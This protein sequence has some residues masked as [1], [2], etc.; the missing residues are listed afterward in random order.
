MR[1]F[2]FSG[3]IA[4][5]IIAAS[6]NVS[7]KSKDNVPAAAPGIQFI[8]DDWNLALK[9]AQS[10]NKLVFVD[11]YTTWCG[12]CKM[13]KQYTF[14]DSA[15][16]NF[17]NKNFV[18]VSIDGEKGVGPQLAQQFAV[19]GYP[20]LVVADATGKPVL[21]TMGFIPADFLLQFATEAV[22]RNQEQIKL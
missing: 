4:V 21:V 3:F 12:P 7:S 15:V 17:F 10:Q 11:I 9:K 1:L 2:K 22:K 6:C 14:T 19:E 5:I 8:E 20:T 18:N 16:G 13:L